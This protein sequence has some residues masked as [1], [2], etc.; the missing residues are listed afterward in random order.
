MSWSCNCAVLIISEARL[1]FLCLLARPV[2]RNV[3]IVSVSSSSLGGSIF[4]S[5]LLT[6]S[7]RGVTPLPLHSHGVIEAESLRFHVV[8]QFSES[9]LYG[10]HFES[11][12]KSV[13]L[14]SLRLMFLDSSSTWDYFRCVV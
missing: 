4:F 10:W 12:R 5:L 6:L 11:Q 13:I 2:S 1:L 3:L 9:C 14:S 7:V 8:S